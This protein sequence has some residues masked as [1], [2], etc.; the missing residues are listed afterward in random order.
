MVKSLKVV[1]ALLFTGLLFVPARVSAL[2]R[3]CDPGSSFRRAIMN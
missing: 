2:E 1:S 3:M